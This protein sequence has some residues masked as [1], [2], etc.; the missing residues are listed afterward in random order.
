[1]RYIQQKRLMLA[2]DLIKE[3]TP[4][5]EA[6]AKCGYGDYSAFLRAFKKLFGVNPRDVA[7]DADFS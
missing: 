6:A 4:V 5:A 3:G 2:A 1:H 7:W